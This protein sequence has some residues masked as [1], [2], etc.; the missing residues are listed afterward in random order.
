MKNLIK[1]VLKEEFNELD[2][3]QDTV[4][5]KLAKNE[6]W[7]LVNDIDRESIE[8]GHEIQKYL[9]D[10][11]Y[12]WGTGDFTSLKDFCI[13]TIYHYGNV[14]DGN[15]IYYQDG[16]R[17]AEVRISDKDIKSGKHMIYYW[18]DL[19]PKTINE[20]Q[21]FDWF[22]EIK[23]TLN[24]AFEEGLIKKGSV[25]TLSGELTDG[26]GRYPIQVSDFKIKIEL[27]RGPNKYFKD[28]THSF[29]IPLQ[30]KYFEHLGYN[31]N[32]PENSIRFAS[33]D[34]ELEVL[35]IS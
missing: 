18:S 28:I 31:G 23:P 32:D 15:Q 30:E 16:C 35:D 26:E 17:G 1:R 21:G 6:D 11:G 25:L 8:E 29:F 9:F 33:T 14:K 4:T 27:L 22:D 3:I 24:V 7:I 13:Y 19:K 12:D 5:A 10:L 34:G 20:S 2:W